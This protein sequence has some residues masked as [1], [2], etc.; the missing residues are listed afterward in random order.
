MSIRQI[1]ARFAQLSVNKEN[2][3]IGKAQVGG[4]GGGGSNVGFFSFFLAGMNRIEKTGHILTDTN[5]TATPLEHLQ[6]RRRTHG[7]RATAT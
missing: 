1:E 3:S 4:V 5:P 7:T 6:H 2:F